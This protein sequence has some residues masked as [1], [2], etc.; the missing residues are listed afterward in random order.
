MYY[1]HFVRGNPMATIGSPHKGFVTRKASWCYDQ[2]TFLFVYQFD[3]RDGWPRCGCFS[4]CSSASVSQLDALGPLAWIYVEAASVRTKLH[5]N[6]LRLGEVNICVSELGHLSSGNACRHQAITWSNAVLFSIVSE[7]WI[8]IQ[9]F[10][11]KKMHLKM[12]SAK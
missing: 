5:R 9:W 6:S 7:I 12:S 4:M 10:S 1:W 2:H 11:H 8:E 3:C